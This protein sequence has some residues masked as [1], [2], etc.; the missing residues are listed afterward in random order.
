MNFKSVFYNISK[1]KFCLD[2]HEI[3][4]MKYRNKYMN[5]TIKIAAFNPGWF[6]SGIVAR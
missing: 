5:N 2:D 1:G 6:F 4:S 3:Y